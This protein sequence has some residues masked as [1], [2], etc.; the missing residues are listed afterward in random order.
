MLEITESAVLRDTDLAVEHLQHLR[1]LGVKIA[2]D[3]FG[4]GY[5]SLA[6]LRGLPIDIVKIDRTF[7]GDLTDPT[8]R[9]G[10]ASAILQLAH[11]MQLTAVAEGVETAEQLVRLQQAGCKYAQGFF[12]GRPAD[13]VTTARLPRH[14]NVAMV[15]ATTPATNASA[16]NP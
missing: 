1:A 15:C 16:R 9:G 13:A 2:L 4:T 12:I 6:H 10:I 8:A 5:S 11:N 7:V 3:D 14:T